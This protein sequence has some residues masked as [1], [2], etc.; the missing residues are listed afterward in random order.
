M[1]KE[2]EQ[3]AAADSSAA[4]QGS[5]HPLSSGVSPALDPSFR[6]Q[7]RRENADV[8]NESNAVLK[9][10]G[11]LRDD[12][13]AN[14]VYK[15]FSAR[16]TRCWRGEVAW[17]GASWVVHLTPS[18]DLVSDTVLPVRRVLLHSEHEDQYGVCPRCVAVLLR[19]GV[20]VHRRAVRLRD[21]SELTLGALSHRL[22]GIRVFRGDDSSDVFH[23]WDSCPGPDGIGHEPAKPLTSYAMPEGIERRRRRRGC[24]RRRRGRRCE[25][26]QRRRLARIARRTVCRDC[27]ASFL[28]TYLA[29]GAPEFDVYFPLQP[30]ASLEAEQSS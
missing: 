7:L 24:G 30:S 9:E 21:P 3:D 18:C 17:Q 23:L 1:T 14:R 5:L 13:E 25:D 15:D 26:A 6:D 28:R 12:A 4:V 22:P 8:V 20:D 2:E 19:D 11:R 10:F 29:T 27:Y 16:A